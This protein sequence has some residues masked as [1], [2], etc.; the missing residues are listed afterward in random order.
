MTCLLRP[1]VSANLAPRSCWLYTMTYEVSFENCFP[2][3]PIQLLVLFPI[4]VSEI[5]QAQGVLVICIL[6]VFSLRQSLSV[7]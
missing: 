4:I 5:I 7:D 3:E 2:E 6:E 1:Y